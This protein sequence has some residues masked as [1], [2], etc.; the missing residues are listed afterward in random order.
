MPCPSSRSVRTPVPPLGWAA[1]PF[2]GRGDVTAPGHWPAPLSSAAHSSDG[3]SAGF[4]RAAV[5]GASCALLLGALS[6]RE[7]AGLCAQRLG[8][9]S[10]GGSRPYSIAPAVLSTSPFDGAVFLADARR[11]PRGHA[12]PVASSLNERRRYLSSGPDERLCM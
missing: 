3:S 8:T 2:H 9:V 7:R 10:C 1:E 12:C 11:R 5:G 4:G 6:R